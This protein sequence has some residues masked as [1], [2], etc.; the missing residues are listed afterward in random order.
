MTGTTAVASEGDPAS[1]DGMTD[2]A[3]DAAI[4][5]AE[6]SVEERLKQAEERERQRER[7]EAELRAQLRTRDELLQRQ[8]ADSERRLAEQTA[9]VRELL[10]GQRRAEDRGFAY[11]REE[12]RARMR[13][14]VKEADEAAYD[15]A[16]RDLTALEEAAARRQPPPD[17]RAGARNE[18]RG[19]LRGDP[20]TPAHDAVPYRQPGQPGAAAAS[21]GADALVDPVA[22]AWVSNNPWFAADRKLAREAQAIEANLLDD[23]PYM[24]TETRLAKVREE[25]ARR[26]PDKFDNP[27]RRQAPTV[28]TPGGQVARQPKPKTLTLA[29]LDADSRAAL[30]AIKRVDPKFKDETYLAGWKQRQEMENEARARL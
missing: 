24:T 19:D 3:I 29:D 18:P 10:D 9:A 26:H 20:G 1:A 8:T 28:A 23:D 21:A 12:I 17:Q 25:V 11:Y 15:A 13:K 7:T 22:R 2:A 27:A 6:P 5:A 14:A 4:G 16:E 30:A